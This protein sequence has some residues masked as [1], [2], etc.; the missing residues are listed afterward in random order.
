[1]AMDHTHTHISFYQYRFID[2]TY[3][4]SIPSIGSNLFYYISSTEG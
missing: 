3:I 2:L 4:I 1:M